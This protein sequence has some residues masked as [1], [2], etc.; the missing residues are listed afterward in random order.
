MLLTLWLEVTVQ[1]PIE[2]SN[3]SIFLNLNLVF[4][5]AACSN[6]LS[7][8]Y[9]RKYMTWNIYMSLNIDH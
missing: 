7:D 6:S 8:N 1:N 9:P 2:K 3:W 4:L 5:W